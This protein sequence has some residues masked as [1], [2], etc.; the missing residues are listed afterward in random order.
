MSKHTRS[1][2]FSFSAIRNE[3]A[4]SDLTQ[5]R[6]S[7]AFAVGSMMGVS[8]RVLKRV[9]R[10]ELCRLVVAQGDA[11]GFII[12][13]DCS[14]D[15]ATVTSRKIRKGSSVSLTGKL[16]TFGRLAVC[17]SDCCLS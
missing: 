12:I 9:S 11:S 14:T 3:L 2:S 16:Q 1:L 4:V 10:D 7:L 8:G 17:L 5:A 15:A 13:A 6:L